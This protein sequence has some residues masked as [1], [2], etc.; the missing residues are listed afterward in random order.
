MRSGLVWTL[1]ICLLMVA[2]SNDGAVPKDILPPARMQNV[3]WDLIQ[4]DKFSVLFLSKDSAKNVKEERIRLYEDVFRIHHI[5]KE[6]FEK[7]YKF[8]L[9]RP[10]ISKVM[11][12]SLA[13]FANRKRADVYS[14]PPSAPTLNPSITPKK[15]VQIGKPD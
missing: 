7:S 15:K 12:D 6:E 4:A 11:F 10:D 1:V 8:Y 2:C 9:S 13:A 5:S 3:L 14:H